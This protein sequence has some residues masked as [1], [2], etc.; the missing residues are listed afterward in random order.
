MVGKERRAGEVELALEPE[1]LIAGT[2]T[3]V[4]IESSGTW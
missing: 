2:S 1:P 4:S 3:V